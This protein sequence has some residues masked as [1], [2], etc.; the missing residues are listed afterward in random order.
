MHSILK[1]ISYIELEIKLSWGSLCYPFI[2][3]IINNFILC[4]GGG[5]MQS[6]HITTNV[7]SWSSKNSAI[8]QNYDALANTK[9]ES[10]G[11]S[12]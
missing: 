11:Y 4:L 10:Y 5:A 12:V 1:Y 8:Y 7:V 3:N 9:S 2:H 6:V